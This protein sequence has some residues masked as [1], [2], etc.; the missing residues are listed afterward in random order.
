[1]L[2]FFFWNFSVQPH[3]QY[4]SILLHLLNV[5]LNKLVEYIET[6]AAGAGAAE[7]SVRTKK[8]CAG[9]TLVRP[10]TLLVY[11]AT[12]LVTAC[13]CVC[14]SFSPFMAVDRM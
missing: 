8:Q 1:M 10:I 13:V 4:N 11:Y 9:K 12:S 14:V 3:P 6:V 2:L 7:V 5:G